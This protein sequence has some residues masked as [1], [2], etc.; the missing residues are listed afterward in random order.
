MK[1]LVIKTNYIAIVEILLDVLE[2]HQ[3]LL[4]WLH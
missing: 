2:H 3:K 4:C 1:H